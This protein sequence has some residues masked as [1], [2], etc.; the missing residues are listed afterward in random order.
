[1]TD[2]TWNSY[3]LTHIGK[4][5]KINQDAFLNLP[6][7]QLWVV[8]DGMG[9]HK[10]G[11]VASASIINSLEALIPEQTIGSTVKKIY[12]A[13]LKVNQKLLN[14]AAEGGDNEIIGSTVVI[15]LVCHQYCVYLWSGDSRIYIFRKGVL[16]QISRDHNNKSRLLAEGSSIK[17]VK[18][19]PFSQILT[20]AIGGEENLY[21]D[22]QIQEIRDGDIFLLCS[23]GLN[24]EV[25]DTEI[26]SILKKASIEESLIQ[27]IELALEREAQ[28]NIS[29]ILTQASKPND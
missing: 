16:K 4:K 8:A 13:L 14:L 10:A 18:A 9:G 28:D 1:M 20:H 25:C 21:L 2:F 19:Y 6:N 7:K 15:L 11:E 26:E 12:S 27:L 22:A 17:E 3:G 29:I 24:K 23:D 5:R